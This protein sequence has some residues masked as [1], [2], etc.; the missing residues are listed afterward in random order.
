MEHSS[1]AAGPQGPLG[2]DDAGQRAAAVTPDAS[3]AVKETSPSPNFAD[4]GVKVLG[5]VAAGV[6]VLGFVTLVGGAILHAQLS[7]AGLPSDQAVSALPQSTLLVVGARLLVPLLSVVALF[8]SVLWLIENTPRLPGAPGVRSV[9]VA[10][11]LGL[12]V[13]GAEIDTA[14]AHGAALYYILPI[15]VAVVLGVGIWFFGIRGRDDFRLFAILTT[16]GA[17]LFVS[18]GGYAISY[19]A[20]TVRPVAVARTSGPPVVG[21]YAAANGSEVEVGEVCQQRRGSNGGSGRSG[22]L[23]VIPRSD[24]QEI[25]LGTNGSLADAL[26]REHDLLRSLPGNSGARGSVVT[27]SAS[28]G[29]RC[30]GAVAALLAKDRHNGV[31]G[32]VQGP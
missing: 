3:P 10:G 21:I 26:A 19:L 1:Q 8:L 31:P 27:A 25:V 16:I 17:T 11:L 14:R 6:G 24:V 23:V 15:F 12:G 30:T 13:I 2:G 22:V 5:A 9:G 32:V 29:A 28:N 18:A 20:P 4:L 7:A